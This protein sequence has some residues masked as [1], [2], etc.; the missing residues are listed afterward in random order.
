MEVWLLTFWLSHDPVG[1]SFEGGQYQTEWLCKRGAARQFGHWRGVYGKT[2][3]WK[4]ELAVEQTI[5]AS[6][7]LTE[8]GREPRWLPQ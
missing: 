4:C 1:S 5:G 6:P 2:L 7:P 8:F 3:K